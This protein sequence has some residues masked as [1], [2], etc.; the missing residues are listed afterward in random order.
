MRIKKQVA[1]SISGYAISALIV[2]MKETSLALLRMPR[3]E[4]P[5]ASLFY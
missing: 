4:A 5:T 2:H 3:A 1:I